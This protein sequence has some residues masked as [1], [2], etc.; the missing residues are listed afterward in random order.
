[1]LTAP[2]EY[3][4]AVLPSENPPD[5]KRLNNTAQYDPPSS[6]LRPNKSF[7][8][9]FIVLTAIFEL[10]MARAQ[11]EVKRSSKGETTSEVRGT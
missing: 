11:A 7:V 5:A 1:M 2:P 10:I 9:V 4:L 3:V 6:T 8:T